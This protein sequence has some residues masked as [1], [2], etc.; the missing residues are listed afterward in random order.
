[1]AKITL[2]NFDSS[3]ST[4]ISN[5]GRQY[6]RGGNILGLEE[7]MSGHW[8]A[9]VEGSEQYAVTLELDG[10]EVAYWEC[11]C[12]YDDD[13]KLCKHVVA[14]LY[15]LR[16]ERKSIPG[17][18]RGQS[19]EQRLS[20]A[21]ETLKA[22]RDQRQKAIEPSFDVSSALNVDITPLSEGA[23]PAE[24]YALWKKLGEIEQNIIKTLAI[25]W[26]KCSST[27]IAELCKTSKTL[28]NSSNI[29]NIALL[30]V[31]ANLTSWGIIEKKGSEYFCE[32]PFAHFLCEEIYADDRED[33]RQI[34][35]ALKNE[36]NKQL[37]VNYSDTDLLFRNMRFGLYL[38]QTESFRKNYES[39]LSY[40]REWPKD[41]MIQFWLPETESGWNNIDR[42]PEGIRYFLL[43]IRMDMMLENMIL[44][45]PYCHYI[46]SNIGKIT[47]DIREEW[48]EKLAQLYLFRGD[49]NKVKHYMAMMGNLANLESYHA[50]LALL[51]GEPALAN[52][53][54]GKSEKEWRKIKR[55]PKSQ[56]QG[57]PFIFRVFN[58]LHL[59]NPALYPKIG[60][61]LKKYSAYDAGNNAIFFSLQNVLRFLQND[62]KN[63]I[64]Q[65]KIVRKDNLLVK[66]FHHI[67]CFIIDESLIDE[68]EV[69]ALAEY[70][71]SQ[72]YVWLARE[73]R[74]IIALKHG[75][76]VPPGDTVP[77]VQSFPRTEEW[78]NALNALLSLGAGAQEA[79][80]KEN[81]S[82]IVWL[83]DFEEKYI[84]AR[85]QTFGKKGWTPGRAV[86][87]DRLH[88]KSVPGLTTQD[89]LIIDA[90]RESSWWYRIDKAEV[91]KNLAGHPLLF[92][93]KSPE[94]AVLLVEDNPVLVARQVEGGFEMR[95][96]PAVTKS[97]FEIVKE[98]P[99]RYKIYIITPEHEKVAAAF[100]GK[101]LIVP[102]RGLERFNQAV[103]GLAHIV[104]VQSA[105]DQHDLPE[106]PADPRIC[107]H[108]LPVG[109]GFHIELY[110]KPFASSPPYFRPG[111]GESAV[112][113]LVEGQRVRTMRD[114]DAE[115]DQVRAVVEK[116]SFL[117]ENEPEDQIWTVDNA[118]TCLEVL[119]DL[120]PLLAANE[121]TLEWPRGE[122]F[123]VTSVVGMD[124]FRMKI[125]Q[126]SQWFEVSG[127]LR[128]D[129]DRV[130][131]MQELLAL[132]E[133]QK[134]PFIEVG[135][136]KFLAITAE[137]RKRLQAI[138]GLLNTTKNGTLQLHPLAA[139]AFQTLTD[140]VKNADLDIAFLKNREKLE[141]AFSQQFKLPP[142]FKASLRPYQQEGFEWLHRMAAWG[143]GACLADD[144][145]LGK[146]VQALA[147]LTDRAAMG[148]ALVMAPVSVCR[149]WVNETRKFAPTLNPILFGEGDREEMVKNAKK[150]DLLIATYDLLTRESKILSSKK[151]STIILDEAQAIKNRQTK[152]SEAA[153]LLN[154]D[155]RL[156]MSGTPVENHLGELWNLFQFANPGLLGS[157]DQFSE[158]FAMPIEKF[159]DNDR[160]DQLR[161]LV[162]PFI[163]RR[164]KDE[165]L[166]EL[167]PKTEIVLEVD[168]TTEERS[169]YEALRRKA[170][171]ALEGGEQE[172]GAGEKHLRILAEIM[173]LR[174]AACH[175]KLV[176]AN[177]GIMESSKEKLFGEI[178]EELID[179][180]HKALVFSQ[181]VTHLA[182]LE[183][184]LKKQKI[185]YQYLDGQTPPAKRQERIDAFQR[186]EGD[187]FLISLKAGGS[188]LNLTAADYVIHMDP[189]WNPAVEDQATDRAHRIGQ[190]KP[191]TVYRLVTTGTIEEKIILLHERKRDLAD[192]LLSGTGVSAKLSADDL[193][194]LLREDQESGL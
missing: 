21:T 180:G 25:A 5:R 188:G 139:T 99:T 50:I 111:K 47:D 183:A 147:F 35:D 165:V 174:R 39:I 114:L 15:K 104:T 179:N 78:E 116:V 16:A 123:K 86:A 46:E 110:V 64:E 40:S 6:F 151:W 18:I 33:F 24:M 56:L 175:P 82:R 181:F 101:S 7:V 192:S 134:S 102:E 138:N 157:I 121:I 177:A 130:L 115:N 171:E 132:S 117:S 186:G 77:L 162:Q 158:R 71:E 146:T 169:F 12:P 11:T 52:E 59:Q 182:I 108:L 191:V 142:Q 150:G 124:Q 69:T 20:K 17:P 73:M 178:V 143:V 122:K 79:Q 133:Q 163:L 131:S 184:H 13:G 4:T 34:I 14:I 32:K 87:D 136:G 185:A 76:N 84:E 53:L 91:W 119:T 27:R 187:L 176:D 67:C 98:T 93:R 63:A 42:Y 155:F 168:L 193:M 154:A 83:V 140:A 145:G 22:V 112:L 60:D 167:P 105:I 43:G 190:E 41:R 58:L 70:L 118:N 81:D 3:V 170:L 10:N 149:N 51:K 100:N 127:E 74:A 135:P 126:G 37:W 8:E 144:M 30:P 103:G 90:M 54:F 2:S 137:F 92:L 36:T 113:A 75:E 128:I 96:V 1:M 120:H 72:N 31:L 45:D 166:K 89:H 9:T 85:E 189:W 68:K 148:P 61:I 129:E 194:A 164:R 106:V 156:I 141:S 159:G 88:K 38:E 65:I 44:P 153:M 172:T 62:K 29:T 94:V 160:R 109:D 95:F 66:I 80:S 55:S 28:N 152:R 97:G 19:Y 107:L 48:I 125:S 49:W 173:K 23:T 161:R 57:V 26:D